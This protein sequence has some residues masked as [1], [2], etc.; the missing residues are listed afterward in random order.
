VA[1]LSPSISFTGEFSPNFHLENIIW[2]YTKDFSWKE[3]AQNSPDFEEKN[4]K[5]PDFYDKF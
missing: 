2:T 3:K 1:L 5:S 4:S